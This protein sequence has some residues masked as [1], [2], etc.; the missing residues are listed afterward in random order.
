[1]E[2]E[3]RIAVHDQVAAHEIREQPII[4]V[5]IATAGHSGDAAAGRELPETPA[6]SGPNIAT[7]ANA[8]RRSG[9]RILSVIVGDPRAAGD[10]ATHVAGAARAGVEDPITGS[11]VS[12]HTADDFGTPLIRPIRIAI[13]VD[14]P[15]ENFQIED[16]TDSL[17][18]DVEVSV[19]EIIEIVR[20]VLWVVGGRMRERIRPHQTSGEFSIRHV[21]MI[22]AV[23]E[24]LTFGCFGKAKTN[25]A[26]VISSGPI[27]AAIVVRNIDS[28]RFRLSNPSTPD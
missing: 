27:D 20:L 11:A 5:F 25:V 24:E 4:D 26:V 28:E 17:A 23:L 22:G 3:S 13:G 19:G 15:A 21:V 7:T 6:V 16:G 12:M 18:A 8:P 10:R 14:V 9:L 2:T 1:M